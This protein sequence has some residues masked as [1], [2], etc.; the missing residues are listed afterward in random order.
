MKRVRYITERYFVYPGEKVV[1][2][3]ELND[4]N[5]LEI[6]QNLRERYLNG[7]HLK[8]V[9]DEQETLRKKIS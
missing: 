1:S 2:E 6:R 5:L 4:N 9:E 3:T 8:L 7:L